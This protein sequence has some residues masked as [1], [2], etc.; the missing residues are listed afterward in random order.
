MR[1]IIW[2]GVLLDQ[3]EVKIYEKNIKDDKSY[4][5]S[6]DEIYILKV[7][8]SLLKDDF[9]NFGA[10]YDLILLLKAIMI[11]AAE[12]LKTYLHDYHYYMLFPLLQT[13]KSYRTYTRAKVLVSFYISSLKIR[14][15]IVDVVNESDEGAYEGYI[16]H[17]IDRLMEF[18]KEIDPNL[19]QKLT[20][21][22][23]VEDDAIKTFHMD[24]MVSKR[25]E[26]NL[27]NLDLRM[28]KQKVIFGELLRQFL[29]R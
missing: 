23:A 22:L 16:T 17:I 3:E 7:I 18:T 12:Y 11:Y 10:D 21:L 24:L 20:D 26:H 4:T 27:T 6:K 8:Q 14:S 2:K 29:E 25:G 1:E 15:E 19:A 28:S 9:H 5:I 13:F